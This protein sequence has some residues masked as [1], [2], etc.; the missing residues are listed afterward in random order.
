MT[1]PTAL[2]TGAAS[3]IGAALARR[4]ADT[5]H[6]LVLVDRDGERL[7]AAPFPA[8]T[9]RLTADLAAEDDLARVEA[10]CRDGLDLLVNNA[11]FGH[12]TR[13]LDTPIAAEIA[14][15]RLH[16]ETV[17][18]LTHAAL[19]PMLARGSGGVLNTASLLGFF[20]SS[21]YSAT[22]AWVINF[23]QA[24]ARAARPHGVTVTALCPGFTRT[25][26]HGSAGMDMATIPG[27]LWLD[28]DRVAAAALRDWRKGKA[29][30]VPGWQYKLVA[31][32]GRALPPSL[33]GRLLSGTDM[34]R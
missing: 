21:T 17:L 1:A 30:S 24:T 20:P 25:G 33:A 34:R 32:F 15:A 23:S 31:A 18:R 19:P 22:K 5:G 13:F 27:F 14:M 28:P 10:R 29:L 9:E 12:P 3:G 7:E 26:F 4:L 8:G 2:V 11:G 16:M 6:R